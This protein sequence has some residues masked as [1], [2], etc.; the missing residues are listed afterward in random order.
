MFSFG[1]SAG[2]T[3][4]PLFPSTTNTTTQTSQPQN[5]GFQFGAAPT[6]S[7]NN[8]TSIG[9]GTNGGSM[10]NYGTSSNTAPTSGTATST[11]NFGGNLHNIIFSLLNVCL[12]SSTTPATSFG[13]T[14]NT[15]ASNSYNSM[16]SSASVPLVASLSTH[17]FQY[18]QQCYEPNHSN[19]RFR[20]IFL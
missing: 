16:N 6:S 8:T 14:L 9:A 5:T 7:T 12:G 11:F 2:S 4:N 17:P 13:S 15:S 10:F 1:S 19:Y 20:V 18:L 3:G